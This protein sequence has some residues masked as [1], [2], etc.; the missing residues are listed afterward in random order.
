MLNALYVLVPVRLNLFT[1]TTKAIGWHS[2]KHG[3]KSRSYDKTQT[4]RRARLRRVEEDL[5]QCWDLLRP[6]QGQRRSRA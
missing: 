1:A 5:D 3:K 4:Q 6:A 2:N